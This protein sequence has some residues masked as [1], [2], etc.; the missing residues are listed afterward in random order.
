MKNQ[1]VKSKFSEC[2]ACNAAWIGDVEPY[3][4]CLQANSGD[5]HGFQYKCPRCSYQ[6]FESVGLPK[7]EK[8]LVNQPNQ[9]Q[10]K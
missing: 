9:T 5:V 10:T 3:M 2:P 1:I 7:Q 8:P 4:N 6:W